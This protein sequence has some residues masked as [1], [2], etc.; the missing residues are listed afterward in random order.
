MWFI[1]ALMAIQHYL[2]TVAVP[3]TTGQIQFCHASYKQFSSVAFLRGL[4]ATV[5][6]KIMVLATTC[7]PTP[8]EAQPGQYYLWTKCAQSTYRT[9]LEGH[10]CWLTAYSTTP[11]T[12][13][14]TLVYLFMM[15]PYTCDACTMSISPA[16]TMPL[17]HLFK[18]GHTTP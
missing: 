17:I 1:Q 6:Q 2:C 10:I 18:R 16:S 11:S 14:K 9:L 13:W 8:S 7:S 3:Q 15:I 4:D 5:V 12:T